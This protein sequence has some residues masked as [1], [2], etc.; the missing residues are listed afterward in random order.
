MK[1]ELILGAMK[2]IETDNY[3]SPYTVIDNIHYAKDQNIDVLIGPEWSLTCSPGIY[4]ES[5][6][7]GR[8]AKDA[9]EILFND[10]DYIEYGP[11]DA[12]KILLEKIHDGKERFYAIPH[13]P[14]SKRE[15]ER[16]LSDVKK[17]SIGSD[18]TIFPGTAMFYD[19]NR[20]LYNVMPVIS[21]GR[22]IKNIYKFGDGSGSAFN[23]DG[24]LKLF[25][26][27]VSP[28]K[29][30]YSLSY[31]KDPAVYH[32]GIKTAA[33]ICIDTGILN[34]RYGINDLDLQILS[35]CGNSYAVPA[36]GDNGFIA[37]TDGFRSAEI[38]VTK[39]NGAKLKPV[40]K[41]AKMGIFRLDFYK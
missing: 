41:S 15:Y 28:D 35:S 29:N 12:K 30:D 33:E 9:M 10:P 18:M 14:H 1:L 22:V 32:N 5:M 4:T 2:N 36:V 24:A 8:K 3:G 40:K 38:K 34:N 26:G 21:N 23:L 20:I 17:A 11:K 27:E 19:K 13:I 31:G 7:I 37:V 16:V 6:I 39:K 25:P